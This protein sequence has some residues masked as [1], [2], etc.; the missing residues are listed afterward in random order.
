[1]WRFTLISLES[2]CDLV[3]TIAALDLVD[4][5]ADPAAIRLLIPRG[6]RLLELTEVERSR[7]RSIRRR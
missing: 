7:I 6:S 1:L 2:Y 5:R 3:D 4:H